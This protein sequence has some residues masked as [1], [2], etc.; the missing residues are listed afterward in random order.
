MGPSRIRSALLLI[1]TLS[2]IA[3]CG[4]DDDKADTTTTS[5][6]STTTT[7]K[8]DDT[9]TTAS[10]TKTT[11][12]TSDPSWAATAAQFRGQDGS[13]HT[14]ACTPNP[15]EQKGSVWG[16]GTYTD[17]SSICTAAVQ[18]GLITFAEG[19]E[20]TYAIAP[21]LA[22]YDAGT[23]NGVT[24]QRYGQ[25]SGSMTFPDAPPGSVEFTTGAES[26]QRNAADRR[27]QIGERFT[28]TCS[29]GGPLGSLWGSGPYTDD[30]SVCTAGV[31]AGVITLAEGGDVTVAIAPGESSYEGSTANGVTS[32]NYGAFDGSFVIDAS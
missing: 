30:S 4:D 31:H 28:V 32:S 21:G 9:T 17:D 13:T 12:A 8:A 3:G 6:A 7:A 16:A 24:S 5:K 11:T 19:G 22:E 26:W 15:D 2:V 27:G 20:V 18:S 29:A 23:A 25:W 14:Q 10:E 1:V